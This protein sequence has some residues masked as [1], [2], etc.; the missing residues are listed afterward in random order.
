[1]F[2]CQFCSP[3]IARFVTVVA[4]SKQEPSL[5]PRPFGPGYEANKNHAIFRLTAEVNGH[6]YRGIN[7][8]KYEFPVFCRENDAC[9]HW[10]CVGLEGLGTR[11]SSL[12]R[13]FDISSST[14]AL[15]P[16][17]ISLLTLSLSISLKITS[18]STRFRQNLR[19]ARARSPIQ[20]TVIL[21]VPILPVSTLIGFFLTNELI[22]KQ[23]RHTM[24]L[25]SGTGIGR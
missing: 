17:L 21:G 6:V 4:H 9:A 23:L 5:V 19:A 16:L 15:E 11:L 10:Q 13:A 7:G 2:L 8:Q 22:K 3:L 24:P 1:M 18:F 12:C 14:S 20:Y 25:T